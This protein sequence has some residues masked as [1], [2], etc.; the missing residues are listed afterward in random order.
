MNIFDEVVNFLAAGSTPQDIVAFRSSGKALARFETLL[1]GAKAETLTPEEVSEL[2]HCMEIEHIMRLAKARARKYLPVSNPK[3][4]ISLEPEKEMDALAEAI[5]RLNNRTHE[6]I[7]AARA[8]VLAASPP[9][10]P[11]PEGK[12]MNDVILGQW[13]GDETD[14]EV[15][16]ALRELS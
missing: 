14:E 8:R 7:M 16:A 11:L 3:M 13:P 12:T 6:E 15:N 4:R 5:A 2:T 1:A 9:P 10:L